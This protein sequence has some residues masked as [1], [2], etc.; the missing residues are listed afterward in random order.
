MHI[1]AQALQVVITTARCGSFAAAAEELHKVPTALSYTV[2]KLE[3]SLGVRLFERD[4]KQLRLTE[5]GRFFIKKGE[6]IL[7]ELD[8]LSFSILQCGWSRKS[9]GCYGG[10]KRWLP[11]II[12]A[13]SPCIWRG[14]ELGF[15]P[16]TFANRGWMM[17]G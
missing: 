11:R 1:T 2:H 9:P 17:A 14:W 15:C 7:A 6:L 10:K 3:S 8:E 13:K 4:G 12:T 5:A 16:G